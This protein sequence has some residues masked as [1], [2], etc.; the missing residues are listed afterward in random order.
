MYAMSFI[1]ELQLQSQLWTHYWFW[2]ACIGIQNTR[3]R[4][5]TNVK[6]VAIQMS[7]HLPFSTLWYVCRMCGVCVETAQTTLEYLPSRTNNETKCCGSAFICAV[8]SSR[9]SLNPVLTIYSTI[10]TNY[11]ETILA[12]QEY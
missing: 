7:P 6:M 3:I 1:H 5:W 4:Q 9:Q 12:D 2:N 11:N 10:I 8:I